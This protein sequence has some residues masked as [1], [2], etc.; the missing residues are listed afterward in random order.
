MLEKF[1]LVLHLFLQ[2]LSKQLV[3]AQYGPSNVSLKK[4]HVKMCRIYVEKKFPS[5]LNVKYDKMDSHSG[6]KKT[7]YFGR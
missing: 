5:F 1:C 3:K 4:L 6:K 2:Q 7:K